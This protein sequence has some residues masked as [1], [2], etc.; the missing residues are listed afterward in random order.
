MNKLVLDNIIFGLQKK[1]GISR[2][3]YEILS[4]L[5]IDPDSQHAKYLEQRNSFDNALRCNLSIDVNCIIKKRTCLSKYEQFIPVRLGCPS[6]F[7]SSYYRHALG[8]GVKNIVT[9]YDCIY[10]KY[11][12][13]SI[14]GYLHAIR[15]RSLKKADAVICISRNTAQD[16]L[17]YYPDVREDRIK[18]TPLAAGDEFRCLPKI[19][20]VYGVEGLILKTG[21]FILYVGNRQSYKNFS[22]L[23]RAM[24]ILKK[25]GKDIPFLVVVGGEN[26]L[27]RDHLSIANEYGIAGGIIRVTHCNNDTLNRLYNMAIAYVCTSKYEGFGLPVLE[28]FKAGCPVLTA[29]NSSLTEVASDAALLFDAED[30]QELANLIVRVQ[31]KTVSGELRALGLKRAKLFSW[32]KTYQETKQVYRSLGAYE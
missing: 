18:V 23:L 25:D 19:T 3:W 16:V 22:V 2:Y 5:L 4:R 8:E 7:H 10:E 24:G 20:Q 15:T 6:V 31:D 28:A 11:R 12:T 17:K 27:S 32:D 14:A 1:G 30:P 29:K 26:T 13:H 9:V 21:S